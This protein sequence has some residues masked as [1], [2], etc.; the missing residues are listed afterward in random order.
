MFCIFQLNTP[1][2]AVV[3]K[4]DNGCIITTYF[5]NEF[6]PCEEDV[7]KGYVEVQNLSALSSFTRG[8]MRV[9]AEIVLSRLHKER[10]RQTI[11]TKAVVT[12]LLF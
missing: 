5:D 11:K 7:I 1:C 3:I 12:L 2:R 8:M 10:V 4:R 9:E 6:S